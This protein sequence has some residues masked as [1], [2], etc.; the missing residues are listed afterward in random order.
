MVIVPS[1]DSLEDELTHRN[2]GRQKGE[3]VCCEAGGAR[4]CRCRLAQAYTGFLS[5]THGLWQVSRQ[6]L[7]AVMCGAGMGKRDRR[8]WLWTVA[9][10]LASWLQALVSWAK[11]LGAPSDPA[12]RQRT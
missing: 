8:G 2:H 9:T 5:T 1:Q 10:A 12:A 6:L 7:K 4:G 3:S 11:P